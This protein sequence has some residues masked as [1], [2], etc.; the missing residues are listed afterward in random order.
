M[1]QTSAAAAYV[2]VVLQ[3]LWSGCAAGR[4]AKVVLEGV[5]VGLQLLH[6]PA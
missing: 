6:L 5:R 2:Q 3:R 4:E 1:Y